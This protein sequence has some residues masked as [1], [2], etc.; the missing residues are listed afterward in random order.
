VLRR[1]DELAAEQFVGR[2]RS[3]ATLEPSAVSASRASA[4]V[5][6]DGSGSP[7]ATVTG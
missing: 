4:A 1:P 3:T 2:R 7:K 5:V 6:V